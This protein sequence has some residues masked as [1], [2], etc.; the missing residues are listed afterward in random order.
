[1][2]AS[3]SANFAGAL[4]NLIRPVTDFHKKFTRP[5]VHLVR[6][7]NLVAAAFR[8]SLSFASLVVI[9]HEFVWYSGA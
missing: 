1:L 6:V 8:E 2:H 3:A 9:D 7:L 4:I 5:R